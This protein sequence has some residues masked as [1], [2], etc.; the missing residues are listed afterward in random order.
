V[1]LVFSPAIGNV[2]T[3][4]KFSCVEVER[5]F[6]GC[7]T[8]NAQSTANIPLRCRIKVDAFGPDGKSIGSQVFT[9]EPNHPVFADMGD[10]TINLPAAKTIEFEVSVLDTPGSLLD[11]VLLNVLLFPVSF[12]PPLQKALQELVNKGGTLATALLFDNVTYTQYF[13]EEDC[14]QATLPRYM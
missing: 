11:R 2:T 9:Y 14:K 7:T 13:T 4:P 8:T 12:F 6:S 10:F 5:M 1:A 3:S